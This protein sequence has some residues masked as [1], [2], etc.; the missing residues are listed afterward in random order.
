MALWNMPVAVNPELAQ[1]EVRIQYRQIRETVFEGFY[2]D[3]KEPAS[4]AE[5]QHKSAQAKGKGDGKTKGKGSTTTGGIVV[6]VPHL[7]QVKAIKEGE[8]VTRKPHPLL[9]GHR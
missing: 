8:E 5:L 3:G 2:A 7:C 4:F 1:F 6:R 9:D